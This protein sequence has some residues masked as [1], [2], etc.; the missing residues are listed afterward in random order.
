VEVVNESPPPNFNPPST[1][2]YM[3]VLVQIRE[4]FSELFSLFNNPH[5]ISGPSG[6]SSV[7]EPSSPSMSGTRSISVISTLP[8]LSTIRPTP[9]MPISTGPSIWGTPTVSL[10][11]LFVFL[12]FL[13][14][15]HQ[16][17]CLQ[18]DLLPVRGR[19][20]V[21]ARGWNFFHLHHSY[22]CPNIIRCLF[23]FWMQHS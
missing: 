14:P 19:A 17:L 2:P 10:F 9:S 4:I 6:S 12:T 11:D 7:A 1:S 13:C 3:L 8:S 15:S 16:F 20:L 18:L 23:T 21:S 22:E 5:T